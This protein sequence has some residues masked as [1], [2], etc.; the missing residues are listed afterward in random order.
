VCFV[1][2]IKKLESLIFTGNDWAIEGCFAKEAAYVKHSFKMWIWMLLKDFGVRRT[3]NFTRFW[4]Y[5]SKIR[6]FV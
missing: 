4:E 2:I 6:L 5:L 3:M 1:F